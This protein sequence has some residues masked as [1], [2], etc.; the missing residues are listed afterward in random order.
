MILEAHFLTGFMVGFEWVN[1]MEEVNHLVLDLGIVRFLFTF[2]K[3][4]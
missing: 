1:E 3:S 2:P 4:E